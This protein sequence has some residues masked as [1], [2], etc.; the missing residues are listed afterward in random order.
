MGKKGKADNNKTANA[1]CDTECCCK[2]EPVVGK[3]L[4]AEMDELGDKLAKREGYQQVSG[5]EAVWYYL[6]QKYHWT[7][8]KVRAMG[9]TDIYFCM[10]EEQL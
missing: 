5:L 7:P 2:E 9:L 1:Q 10:K 4:L 3:Q 6:I 8:K